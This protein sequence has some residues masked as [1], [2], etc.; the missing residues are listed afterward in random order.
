MGF[1]MQLFTEA[2]AIGIER[3]KAPSDLLTSVGDGRLN[4]EILAMREVTRIQILLLHG[5]IR[6]HKDGKLRVWGR[7]PYWNWTK[8]GVT[9]LLRTVRYVEGVYIEQAD[10]DRELVQVVHDLQVY[11]DQK[12]H[13][14]LKSRSGIETN[15]MVPTRDERIIYFYSGLPGIATIGAKKLYDIFPAPLQLYEASLEDLMRVSGI[16]KIM[17]TG[18]YNFLRGIR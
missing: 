13:L 11:F 2:G 7:R 18:I 1:D 8:R 15:W 10:N 6:Y 16:G 17:A 12:D 5:K 14:S 3:K 9:N 4:R